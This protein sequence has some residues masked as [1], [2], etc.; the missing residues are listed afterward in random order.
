MFAEDQLKQQQEKEQCVGIG[1]AAAAVND[2]CVG[3]S[4]QP[5]SLFDRLYHA[6]YSG[7]AR[8]KSV[9]RAIRILDQ[10][11]EFCEFLELQEILRS[12]IF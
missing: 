1:G 8:A 2:D 3:Q 5:K 4:P 6:R 11:P 12:E 7:R 9:E 10:H